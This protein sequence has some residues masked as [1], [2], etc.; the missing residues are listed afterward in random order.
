[1]FAWTALS[2]FW[3]TYLSAI[4]F[5]LLWMLFDSLTA[6]F[7]FLLMYAFAPWFVVIWML[8]DRCESDELEERERR[9]RDEQQRRRDRE[10]DLL[11]QRIRAVDKYP[12]PYYELLHPRKEDDEDPSTAHRPSGAAH[13]TA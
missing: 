11:L 13:G 5:V 2:T 10:M 4:W 9:E 3:L 12:N 1:M 6:L 8:F 7:I